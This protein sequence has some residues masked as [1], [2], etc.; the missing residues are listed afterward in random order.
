MWACFKFSGCSNQLL[1]ECNVH[2]QAVGRDLQTTFD[3]VWYNGLDVGD[4]GPANTS[5]PNNCSLPT[6]CNELFG[7]PASDGSFSIDMQ[8]PTVIGGGSSATSSAAP[9]LALIVCTGAL[10]ARW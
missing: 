9:L 8:I 5:N 6:S 1:S 4:G 10:V 7:F 3:N 2:V